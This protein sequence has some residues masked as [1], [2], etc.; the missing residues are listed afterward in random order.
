MS[1]RMSSNPSIAQNPRDVRTRLS[2]TFGIG[3]AGSLTRF[4]KPRNILKPVIEAIIQ[5]ELN[6]KKQ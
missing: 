1:T 3:R 5:D 2:L 6:S 4:V